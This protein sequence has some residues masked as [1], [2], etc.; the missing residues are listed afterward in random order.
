MKRLF[1]I[2]VIF[3]ILIQFFRIDKTNPPINKGMDFIETKNTPEPMANLIRSACYDCHSHETRYPWYA[4]VQP[5]AWLLEKHISDGRTH[6]NF[7]T[8]A[9]YEP[10]RQAHKLYEASEL[11]ESH[12]MPMESYIIGH[13]EAKLSDSQRKEIIEYFQSVEA[14]IRQDHQLS[15]ESSTK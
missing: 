9:T 15:P 13:P 4:N 10:K 6:F 7:S 3:L 11:I 1:Y 8:F 12:E 2:L 14:S 5:L